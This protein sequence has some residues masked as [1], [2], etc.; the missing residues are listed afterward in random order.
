MIPAYLYK[1]IYLLLVTVLT[2]TVVKYRRSLKVNESI[3]GSALL[4]LFMV[5]FIGFRPVSIYFVDMVNYANW[6][7]GAWW[8]FNWSAENLLF[9]NLYQYMGSVFPDGTV[10]FAVIAGIYF[11]GMLVAC[12]KLFPANTLIVFLVCLA[13]F[14]TFSYGTNGIKA[15]AAASL[16]LV[17]LAYRDNIV[18]SVLF[19]FL[20]W[21]FHHSM[22]MPVAAYVLTL[23]F[24]NKKWYFYGWL[25]CLLMA[26][27]HLSFFQN[28][29]AGM[30]DES[31]AG[32]L[33]WEV[34]DDWGGKSG[35]RIDFVIYSAVPVVIGYY[36][37]F[38]YQL[39]DRLYDMML[40]MYLTCNGIWMLCMYAQFTNRIAYLSWFMYPILLVYPC[41]AIVD[42]NHPLVLV[43]QKVVLLHLAFTLF[44]VLIYYA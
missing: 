41:Y 1:Y 16:F 30:T 32:Y 33:N 14:S 29:F 18:V 40:Y 43:R 11:V 26:V 13:A 20:S 36:V 19:L 24:K 37:K 10:F 27:A 3:I 38:K 21:G 7:G 39:E 8:G 22:Q 35:F 9:D 2:L 15:G 5:L 17:A 34:N 25:F 12:R 44:M 4:C 6:W 28:L 42:K 23:I 31:G